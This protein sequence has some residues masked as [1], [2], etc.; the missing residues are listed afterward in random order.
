MES[1]H[2]ILASDGVWVFEQSYLPTMLEMNAYDTICHEHLEYYSL[3]SIM[4]ILNKSNFK[5]VDIELNDINGGSFALTV[6]K[7]GSGFKINT[8]LVE[9]LLYKESL[10]QMNNLVKIDPNLENKKIIYARRSKFM[11][12]SL[13]FC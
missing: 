6:A 9:W 2:S 11:E 8:K 3:K 5:I 13:V 1:I 10:F 12:Q 7:K 4:Y